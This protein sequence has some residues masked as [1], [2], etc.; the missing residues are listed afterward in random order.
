[1]IRRR[2]Q[3]S[4]RPRCWCVDTA[5]EGNRR[6]QRGV[7]AHVHRATAMG[8]LGT[9]MTVHCHRQM[10]LQINTTEALSCVRS[11]ARNAPSPI[12][13]HASM[14]CGMAIPFRLKGTLMPHHLKAASP[15]TQWGHCSIPCLHPPQALQRLAGLRQYANERE[16]A[17]AGMALL[18]TANGF[19][20]L[21]RG[22]SAA[23]STATARMDTP[24]SLGPSPG[25]RHQPPLQPQAWTSPLLSAHISSTFS[26]QVL[27]AASSQAHAPLHRPHLELR[28]TTQ[29]FIKHQCPVPPLAPAPVHVQWLRAFMARD[30]T[31]GGRVSIPLPFN[32]GSLCHKAAND[33]RGS[34]SRQGGLAM[35]H[36]LGLLCPGHGLQQ[37]P[38]LHRF[39][40]EVLPTATAT[41]RHRRGRELRRVGGGQVLGHR[42]PWHMLAPLRTC[43]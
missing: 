42:L 35:V 34:Q 33:T 2:T 13:L 4:S 25:A 31:C 40:V 17:G 15:P 27:A 18:N 37:V 30:Q 6:L 41:V 24:I 43:T 38:P 3:A 5:E 9:L 21:W 11:W 26:A 8:D 39:W 20:P 10:S 23:L 14:K 19:E 28:C 12:E 22:C 36:P 16:G 1:M 7:F 32:M 29:A